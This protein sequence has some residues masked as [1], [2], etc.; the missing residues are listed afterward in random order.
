L[1]TS[2]AGGIVFAVPIMFH[3][4]VFSMHQSNENALPARMPL[5]MLRSERSNC[6]HWALETRKA[7]ILSP[8]TISKTHNL[9][10]ILSLKL[11][12]PACTGKPM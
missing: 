1:A 4:L 10:M 2:A 8:C 12:I 6:A 5:V 11:T 9:A 3:M 7:C